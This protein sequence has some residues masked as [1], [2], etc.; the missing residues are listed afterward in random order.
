MYDGRD[1]MTH[2]RDPRLVRDILEDLGGIVD[3]LLDRLILRC[4]GEPVINALQ[5]VSVHEG[6]LFQQLTSSFKKS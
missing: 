3:H 1:K 2:P 4:F 6:P 5:D